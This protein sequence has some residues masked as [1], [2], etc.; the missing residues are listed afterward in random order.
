MA[1]ST[2]TKTVNIFLSPNPELANADGSYAKPFR[3]LVKALKYANEQ[4][5]S[6]S[7]GVINIYLLKGTHFMS[8]NFVDYEYRQRYKDQYSGNQE[9]TIQ[10]AF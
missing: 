8:R 9:I 5:A 7:K 2:G 4:V 1:K 10:P 3:H 6:L